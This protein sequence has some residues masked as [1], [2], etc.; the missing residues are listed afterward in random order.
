[1][2]KDIARVLGLRTYGAYYTCETLSA[3]KIIFSKPL[4]QIFLFLFQIKRIEMDTHLY[5]IM[6]KTEALK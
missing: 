3:L 2:L 6:L 4:L 5:H 1:M